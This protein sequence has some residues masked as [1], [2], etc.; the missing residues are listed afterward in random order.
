MIFLSIQFCKTLWSKAVVLTKRPYKRSLV[1][2]K[3]QLEGDMRQLRKDLIQ[4]H[5]VIVKASAENSGENDRM[6]RNGCSRI[7]EDTDRTQYEQL[8]LQLILLAKRSVELEYAHREAYLRFDKEFG[9]CREL[10]DL[11]WIGKDIDQAQMV[12]QAYR[13][14]LEGNIH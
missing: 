1:R 2:A 3:K 10:A 11:Q 12:I 14:Q 13:E 8:K 7:K 6:F 5:D 4:V 9:T